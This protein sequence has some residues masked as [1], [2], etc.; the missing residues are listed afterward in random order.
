M[1]K[2]AVFLGLCAA[3]VAGAPGGAAAQETTLKAAYFIAP[4]D[5][6]FRKAFEKFVEAVNER[7]KGKVQIG[8]IIGPEALPPNQMGSALRGGIV[9]IIGVPPSYLSNLVPGIEGLSQ[10]SVEL[11][12]MRT[13]G[14]FDALREVLAEK[15]NAYPLAHFGD[16]PFHIFSNK[17]IASVDDLKGMRVRT[18]NTYRAFLDAAGA[19][20]VS[21]ARGEIY[22]AL[23]RGVVDAYVN[24]SSEVKPG[25]W[26]EVTK[27]RVDPG[28]Y[29][30]TVLIAINRQ[31]WESL[32]PEQRAF[33]E[34]IGQFTET[35]ISR[36]LTEGDEA[37]ARELEEGGMEVLTLDETEA[38]KLRDLAYEASWDNIVQ[39]APEF[40][41]K[42]RGLIYE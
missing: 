24:I 6:L 10:P 27:Y 4:G 34:E 20:P 11:A 16:V 17:P 28:F 19:I 33:L 13:N 38:A 5:S 7:G 36:N 18:T 41:P 21:T 35:E 39:Q 1:R 37:A 29:A 3:L 14:T 23:E 25:G 31:T 30:S 32:T 15:A 9:D 42:L 12:D 2:L 40:G 8:D 22:T 26:Q